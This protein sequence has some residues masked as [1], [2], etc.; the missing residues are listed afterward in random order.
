MRLVRLEIA[1]H[2]KQT[3]HKLLHLVAANNINA[4]GVQIGYVTWNLRLEVCKRRLDERADVFSHELLVG[5]EGCNIG[6][7]GGGSGHFRLILGGSTA[8]L[9]KVAVPQGCG[10]GPRLHL[11]EAA[12]DES[13]DLTLTV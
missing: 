1:A 11:Q 4:C 8:T 9:C 6:A 12:S 10:D 7:G 13:A 2:V 3:V 5:H